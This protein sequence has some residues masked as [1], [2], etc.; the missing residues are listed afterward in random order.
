MVTPLDEIEVQ[1]RPSFVAE[2]PRVTILEFGADEN[3]LWT[4]ARQIS[5]D[6]TKENFDESNRFSI[7]REEQSASSQRRAGK[8]AESVH[9]EIEP[10][11]QERK[12][13]K[14][15][16][17]LGGDSENGIRGLL[18]F[19]KKPGGHRHPRHGDLHGD[20]KRGKVVPK[21]KGH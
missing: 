20:K 3:A 1:R 19:H 16:G 14:R 6:K 5:L 9:P 2:S 10:T 7:R 21:R 17:A 13:P 8:S 4:E 15:S 11:E 18:L 12:R